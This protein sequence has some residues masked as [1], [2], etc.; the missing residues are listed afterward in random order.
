MSLLGVD[1]GT[2]GCKAAIFSAEG[3]LLTAAYR[4]YDVRA[5]QPG[6]A[7][8][9]AAAVWQKVKQTIREAVAAAA[10][11]GTEP[12]RALAISSLGE[13]VVPVS[14][15]RKILGPSMLNFDLRGAAYLEPLREE[16]D[17]T[18]LYRVNGNALGNHYGL[19]KL[20]WIKEHRP[21]LYARTDKFLLW[22][23]FVAFMLGAEPVV[24][25]TLANRTLLFDLAEEDWSEDLL[26]ISGIDREKLPRT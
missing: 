22:S 18:W 9:D 24:D 1:V 3:D 11:R 2:T 8:L 5:P 16:I 14:R 20:L 12:V 4:E 13:A 21:E 19:T 25:Y 7:E 10:G 6:W 17:E 15:E 23:A 26:H